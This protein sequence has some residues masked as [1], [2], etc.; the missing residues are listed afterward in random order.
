MVFK[1]T[2]KMANEKYRERA[3]LLFLIDTP[4]LMLICYY[5]T[6]PDSVDYYTCADPYILHNLVHHKIITTTLTN[7]IGNLVPDVA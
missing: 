3:A 4:T 1:G 6:C 2:M 7:Y 5:L